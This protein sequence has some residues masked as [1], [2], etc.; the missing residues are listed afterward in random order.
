ME[1]AEEKEAL[2]KI[3]KTAQRMGCNVEE[4]IDA[5]KKESA[6]YAEELDRLVRKARMDL[7]EQY[8]DP[9]KKQA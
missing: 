6:A 1:R 4:M 9:C 3:E 7:V 5:Y 2:T 8:S